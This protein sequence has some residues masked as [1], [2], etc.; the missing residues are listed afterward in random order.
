LVG[1]TSLADR[2]SYHAVGLGMGTMRL[3]ASQPKTQN[4]IDEYLLPLAE[5]L[6]LIRRDDFLVIVDRWCCGE[7]IYGPMLRGKSIIT[8][9]QHE[10]VHAF[11]RNVGGLLTV[12]VAD[13]YKLIER[14]AMR[15]DTLVTIQ[16]VIDANR[17]FHLHAMRDRLLITTSDVPVYWLLLQAEEQRKAAAYHG[18]HH[19]GK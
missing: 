17:Q 3:H 4:G 10:D 7:T 5:H 15:G 2:L 9:E 12:L 16:Q 11:L 1:K 19:P 6:D 13:E 14:Y 18:A 8:D